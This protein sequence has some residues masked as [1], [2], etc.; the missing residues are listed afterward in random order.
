[1]IEL[2]T[3]AEI[4]AMKP[5]GEFVANTL[6]ALKEASRVGVSLLELDAIAHDMIR[7]RGAESCYL[8]Y[9]PSFGSGPFGYVLC[10]SVNDAV[11]HGKPTPYRLGDGD[12][13]SLDFAV[14]VDGWVADSAISFAVG[15]ARQEDLELIRLTE[16]A[17]DAAIAVARVGNKIGDI[18]HAIGAVAHAAGV[19]V[20]LEFGGHGVGRTMHGDPHVANDGRPGRGYP[21]RPGLVIA[22]EPWFMRGTDKL[23]TDADGWTLRSSDGSRTAHSEHTIAITEREPIVLTG[24][25]RPEGRD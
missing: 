10:T 23:R 19:P 16:E 24:R 1:M 11:L 17:L 21:L 25:A 8:D 4:E 20:N 14:S 5:A 15:T 7:K 18:S 3:K 9:A 22:L 12:L 2:H 13:L 6:T